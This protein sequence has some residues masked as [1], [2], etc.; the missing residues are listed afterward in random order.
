[1]PVVVHLVE[2]EIEKPEL[3]LGLELELELGL[4]LKQLPSTKPMENMP[5]LLMR[6]INCKN[7]LHPFLAVN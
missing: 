3:G 6:L 4:E 7:H 2:C 5:M 1:M